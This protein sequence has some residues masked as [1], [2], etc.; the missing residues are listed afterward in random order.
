MFNARILVKRLRRF[1]IGARA[2]A[3]R[4]PDKRPGVGHGDHVS[5]RLLTGAERA[6]RFKQ[7][8]SCR[9]DEDRKEKYKACRRGID[10][11]DAG[12][13]HGNPTGHRKDS[14]KTD[15][16]ADNPLAMGCRRFLHQAHR[17]LH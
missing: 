1:R 3:G 10:R 13:N 17:N 12:A 15:G 14:Q 9:T 11:D 6:G 2:K 4:G 5:T 16:C 8:P 7:P